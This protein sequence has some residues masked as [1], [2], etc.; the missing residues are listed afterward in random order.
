MRQCQAAMTTTVNEWDV[1]ASFS[2]LKHDA[3]EIDSDRIHIQELETQVS[4]VATEEKIAL[5][6]NKAN[7]VDFCK[8]WIVDSG[9]SNHMTGDKEKLHITT[10]YKSG[11]VVVTADN[12]M[13]PIKHIGD[14]VIMPCVNS[15]LIQL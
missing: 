11:R 1:H 6:E 7:Q 13:L 10:E 14:T 12:T 2:I 3:A 5:F 8:V 4:C 9:A 15:Q